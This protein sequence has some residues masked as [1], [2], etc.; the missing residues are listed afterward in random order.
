M[1]DGVSRQ[2]TKAAAVWRSC[3]WARVWLFHCWFPD[4]PQFR[5]FIANTG[6][7]KPC[8]KC[9]TGA[10]FV[11]DSLLP[12][13]VNQSLNTNEMNS[14]RRKEEGKEGSPD[15]DGSPDAQTKGDYSNLAVNRQVTAARYFEIGTKLS[16]GR[17]GR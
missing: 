12:A 3:R 1:T 4:S 11:V 13:R 5:L 15:Y 2:L 17:A 10:D 8:L 7:Q 6:L 16:Y 14:R 9:D